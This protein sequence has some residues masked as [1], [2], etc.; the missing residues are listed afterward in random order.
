[1]HKKIDVRWM[2]EKCPGCQGPIS[3]TDWNA[4]GPVADFMIKDEKDIPTF[5]L[6]RGWRCGF[7]VFG[8]LWQVDGKMIEPAHGQVYL[9]NLL[10]RTVENIFW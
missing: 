1:M 6:L 3:R 10:S 5:R 2:W 8:T 4:Q 9:T 7:A